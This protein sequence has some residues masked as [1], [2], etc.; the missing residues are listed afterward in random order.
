MY[1][2][3][4]AGTLGTAPR[5]GLRGPS[6]NNW[7]FALNKDTK[8]H[9]LGEQGNVQFR[10]EFFN[11]LNHANFSN[12]NATIASLGAPAQIQCGPQFPVVNPSNKT[13]PS[14]QFGSSSVLAVNSTAGQITSTITRSR[15]IQLSLK[16]IF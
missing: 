7:D 8:A 15:Q 9:F 12:P 14:C 3:P 11:L 16:V 6:L 1:D 10:V 5:N 13:A 4:V 2:L